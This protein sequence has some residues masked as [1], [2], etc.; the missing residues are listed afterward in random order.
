MKPSDDLLFWLRREL[1]EMRSSVAAMERG[2]MQVRRLSNG[3]DWIDATASV[4]PDLRERMWQLERLL[5]AMVP[6]PKA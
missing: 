5:K 4:K 6:P 2:Q 3:T 1:D